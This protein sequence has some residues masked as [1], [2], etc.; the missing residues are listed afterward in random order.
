MHVKYTETTFRSQMQLKKTIKLFTTKPGRRFV[1][2]DSINH[3]VELSLTLLGKWLP[4]CG[5]KIKSLLHISWE[6]ANKII[7]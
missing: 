3:I 1:K 5:H 7:T 4:G 2:P 6:V